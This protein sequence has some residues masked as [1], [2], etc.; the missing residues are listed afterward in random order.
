MLFSVIAF[1]IARLCS[2][3]F[4]EIINCKV[5]VLAAWNNHR[6][7][8]VRQL[9]SQLT[10]ALN[11]NK[12]QRVSKRIK[13]QMHTKKKRKKRGNWCFYAMKEV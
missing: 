13:A 10:S 4:N 3:K 5:G 9:G 11:R 6:T 8:G 12:M 1:S 2:P 7:I